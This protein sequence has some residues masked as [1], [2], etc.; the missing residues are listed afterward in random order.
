VADAAEAAGRS[1]PIVAADAAIL[2]GND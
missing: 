2:R 1:D